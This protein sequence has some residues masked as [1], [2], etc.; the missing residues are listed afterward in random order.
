MLLSINQLLNEAEKGFGASSLKSKAFLYGSPGALE[1]VFVAS[2]APRLHMSP[3]LQVE[4]I[5]AREG[6]EGT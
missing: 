3:S 2:K 1:G 6:S 4:G 5:A